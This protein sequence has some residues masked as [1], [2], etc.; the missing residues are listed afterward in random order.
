MTLQKISKQN[1]VKNGGTLNFTYK[2]MIKLLKRHKVKY[3]VD[4]VKYNNFF[5]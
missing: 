5:S 1:L 4:I 2:E 3:K